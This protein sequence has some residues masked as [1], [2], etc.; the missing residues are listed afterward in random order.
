MNTGQYQKHHNLGGMY[1]M[2]ID[3]LIAHT[4]LRCDLTKKFIKKNKPFKL[5]WVGSRSFIFKKYISNRRIKNYVL[6]QIRY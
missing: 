5:V 3:I 1:I 6:R 2:Q 4:E